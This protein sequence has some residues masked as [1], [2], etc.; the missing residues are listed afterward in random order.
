MYYRPTFRA[1]VCLPLAAACMVLGY[2]AGDSTGL[3]RKVADVTTMI[4]LSASGQGVG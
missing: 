2:A 3:R 4:Y 1:F